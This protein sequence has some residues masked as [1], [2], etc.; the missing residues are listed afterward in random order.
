MHTARLFVRLVFC[1]VFFSQEDFSVP[2][3]KT[4]YTARAGTLY[5]EAET[6]GFYRRS[7]EF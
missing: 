2:V 6:T 7:A 1:F 4:D 3:V 5:Q